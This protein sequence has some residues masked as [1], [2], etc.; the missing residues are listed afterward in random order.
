MQQRHLQDEEPAI[1]SV[2]ASAIIANRVV[3]APFGPS[4]RSTPRVARRPAAYDGVESY[5]GS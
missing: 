2:T 5:R 3:P 1:V 4:V